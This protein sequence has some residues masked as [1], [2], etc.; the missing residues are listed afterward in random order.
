MRNVWTIAH[1]EL[2]V[3]FTSPIGYIVLAMFAVMFSIASDTGV[4]LIGPG[5]IVAALC[6]VAYLPVLIV[7][8]GILQTWTTAVWTLAYQQFTGAPKLSPY[9][10]A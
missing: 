7:L 6:F 2:R 5:L 1:R 10:V 8:S 9:A 4:G 3:Y